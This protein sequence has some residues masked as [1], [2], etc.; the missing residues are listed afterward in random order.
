MQRIAIAMTN[1]DGA[2]CRPILNTH[3]NNAI[4]GT[5]ISDWNGG[6]VRQGGLQAH[7]IAR[8]HEHIALVPVNNVGNTAA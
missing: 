8:L 1:Q 7:S 5:P 2:R 4:C 6:L 3:E